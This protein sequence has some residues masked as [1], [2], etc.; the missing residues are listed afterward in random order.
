MLGDLSI[1]QILLLLIHRVQVLLVKL[2]EVLRG[3][4][5]YQKLFHHLL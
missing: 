5:D 3:R 1:N 2:Q 4:E